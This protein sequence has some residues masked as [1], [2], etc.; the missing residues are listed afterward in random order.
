MRNNLPF[1]TRIGPFEVE[2]GME[3]CVLLVQQTDKPGIIS[4]VS[5][6]LASNKVNISYMTVCRTGRGEEAIMAIGVD[7]EPPSAAV[8]AIPKIDGVHEVAVLIENEA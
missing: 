8:D 3:G 2:V 6:V 5:S 4:G 1:I 7:D